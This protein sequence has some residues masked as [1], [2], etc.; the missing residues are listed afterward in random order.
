MG[1]PDPEAKAWI[2]VF[3]PS[4]PDCLTRGLWLVFFRHVET[5]VLP[6]TFSAEWRAQGD[7]KSNHFMAE[8]SGDR[9]ARCLND[10]EGCKVRSPRTCHRWRRHIELV[11]R[12]DPLQELDMTDYD[13]PNMT[14]L[15]KH[16]V[17]APPAGVSYVPDTNITLG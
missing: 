7:I 5:L 10:D 9:G 12:M 16:V 1:S 6:Q 15:A 13:S 8:S 14:S 4:M 11:S 2:G 17:N 3:V